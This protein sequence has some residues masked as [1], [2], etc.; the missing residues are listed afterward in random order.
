M[1]ARRLAAEADLGAGLWAAAMT[2]AIIHFDRRV[3]L[4]E[5]AGELAEVAVDA[6]A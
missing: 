4:V 6:R 5:E 3:L 1:V 2:F